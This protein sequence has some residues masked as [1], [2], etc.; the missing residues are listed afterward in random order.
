MSTQ[1]EPIRRRRRQSRPAWFYELEA[2]AGL[3]VSCSF[4]AASLY[5]HLVA[6]GRMKQDNAS[7]Y[8]PELARR[9][10]AA[11][12]AWGGSDG[13]Y[14]LPDPDDPAMSWVLVKDPGQAPVVVT[15]ARAPEGART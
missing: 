6:G 12:A 8:L 1:A 9:V 4:R 11:L 2:A 3:N 7:V 14:R 15:V 10:N 13:R 5:V